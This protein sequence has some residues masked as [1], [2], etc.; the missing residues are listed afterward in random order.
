M[1]IIFAGTPA[2]ALPSLHRLMEDHEVVAVLTRAPAPVGRKKILTPSPVHQAAEQLG[3]PV[4]TPRSLRGDDIEEQ[5]TALAP[6]AIAVVAYG[7]LIPQNLLQLPTHGWINLHYSLLPRWRGAAPVQYA[8]AAGDTVTGTSVFQIEAGLDTGPIYDVEEH[9]IGNHTAGELLDILSVSGAHQLARVFQSLESGT[10]QSHVQQGDV[11]LA[12]Q[13]STKHSRIDFTMPAHVID[14]RIRGYT[15]E[16]GPWTR[17]NGQ[18]I[19]LGQV[20][21]T[22]VDGIEPGKIVIGKQIL[23]GTSTTAIELTTVTPAGKKTML[24]TAW[25]RGLN[26]DDPAFETGDDHE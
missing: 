16:P 22:S 2:T 1:R 25:A 8:I 20:R 13:L 24:A 11:T 5:L 9:E 15:P 17:Y 23:V 19:K 6:E 10:A 21:I 12:P 26:D 4:L 18:R 14:S 3:I 7:L